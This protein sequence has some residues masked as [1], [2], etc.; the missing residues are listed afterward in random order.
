M[1]GLEFVAAPRLCFVKSKG[2]EAVLAIY[3]YNIK[4]RIF[5]PIEMYSGA[6]KRT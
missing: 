3:I 6:V 4:L 5:T 1:N 2:G